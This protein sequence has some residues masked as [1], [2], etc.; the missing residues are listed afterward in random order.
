M[1]LLVSKVSQAIRA[2]VQ[3]ECCDGC[4]AIAG[5]QPRPVR[6]L[7]DQLTTMQ[8]EFEYGKKISGQ[9]AMNWGRVTLKTR[10]VTV[11]FTEIPDAD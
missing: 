11:Y 4:T 5:V 7:V 3:R 6:E 2:I 8:Q 9:R 1:N 10:I